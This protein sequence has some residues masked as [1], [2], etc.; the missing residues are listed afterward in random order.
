MEMSGKMIAITSEFKTLHS[1]YSCMVQSHGNIF[2][3]VNLF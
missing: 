3:S 1:V 2:R